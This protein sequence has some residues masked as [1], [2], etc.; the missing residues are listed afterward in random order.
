MSYIF[1]FFGFV[2]FLESRLVL[3]SPVADVVLFSV[4]CESAD[5]DVDDAGGDGDLLSSNPKVVGGPKGYGAMFSFVPKTVRRLSRSIFSRSS[6]FV[7]PLS[8]LSSWF[9]LL[10]SSFVSGLSSVNRIGCLTFGFFPGVSLRRFH[11]MSSGIFHSKFE[12]ISC[13]TNGRCGSLCLLF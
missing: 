6:L 7:S 10:S 9:L 4:L 12:G 3:V 2:F 8:F 5:D 1:F 13:R 11:W